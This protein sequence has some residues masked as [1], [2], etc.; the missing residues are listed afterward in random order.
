MT[1]PT[2]PNTNRLLAYCLASFGVPPEE[3]EALTNPETI[4]FLSPQ[5]QETLASATA[6]ADRLI[7]EVRGHLHPHYKGLL[8]DE[9]IAAHLV[10]RIEKDV[11]PDMLIP[12]S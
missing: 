11:N 5:L 1:D 6:R 9:T 3:A 7:A 12:N 2:T 4:L 8:T 10:K